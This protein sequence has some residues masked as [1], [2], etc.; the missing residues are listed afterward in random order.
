MNMTTIKRRLLLTLSLFIITTSILAQPGR[1]G[2][3]N[4]GP[5]ALPA[6]AQITEMVAVVEQTLT[7]TASQT[8]Q[9]SA[10][11]FAHFDEAQKVMDVEKAFQKDNRQAMETLKSDFDAQ[12]KALL[13]K[14]QVKKFES[15]QKN[16]RPPQQKRTRP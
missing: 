9:I 14:K 5:P 15:R 3:R 12:V 11:Y 16:H 1:R 8:T 4:Q 13:N 7:L 10:L 6:Q 2:Q